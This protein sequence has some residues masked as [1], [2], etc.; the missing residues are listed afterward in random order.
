MFSQSAF[1][2]IEL[3]VVI[4]IIAILAAMLLPALQQARERGRS[5]NCVS[6]LKQMGLARSMYSAAYN[7]FFPATGKIN[8]V[9]KDGVTLS[10]DLDGNSSWE[11]NWV[12]GFVMLGYLKRK[13]IPACPSTPKRE[14]DDNELIYRQTYGV[15]LNHY[16]FNHQLGYFVQNHPYLNHP[17]AG[18]YDK[19]KGFWSEKLIKQHDKMMAYADSVGGTTPIKDLLI[20]Y[21]YNYFDRDAYRGGIFTIHLNN[22]NVNY[23][24][25]HTG[26][27]N[28]LSGP[29]FNLSLINKDLQIYNEYGIPETKLVRK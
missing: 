7:G 1:T 19:T 24:D 16:E 25:G 12:R 2:L 9:N 10:T 20:G 6:E 14:S 27:V 4:A 3:L 26:Q 13:D 8:F 17:S 23:L 15:A 18:D 11:G 29:D 5:T 21:A 22:G 28:Y